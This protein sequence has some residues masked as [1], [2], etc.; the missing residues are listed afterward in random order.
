MKKIIAVTLVAAFASSTAFAQNGV[1]GTT[2]NT[3]TGSSSPNSGAFSVYSPGATTPGNPNM[4]SGNSGVG[5]M[6]DPSARLGG[7]NANGPCNGARSTSGN[8]TPSC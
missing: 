2:G 4:G 6:S 5:N 7:V 1:R 3:T 8:N